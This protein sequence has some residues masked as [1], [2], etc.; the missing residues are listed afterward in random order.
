MRT[1]VVLG[2]RAVRPQHHDGAAVQ[3][4]GAL[5]VGRHVVAV[6]VVHQAEV[7]AALQ[8]AAVDLGLLGGDHL[9]LSLRVALPELPDGRGE[10][11]GGRAVDR[12][13]P[14]QPD[15]PVLL[16][17]RVLEPV[18]RVEQ[19]EDVREELA[20][21]VAHPRPVPAPVEQVH[22]QLPFQA[23]HGAAQRGL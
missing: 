17:G 4:R 20:A 15:A 21:G 3:Q 2:E 12:A 14:H 16:V 23:A 7:E 10:Q 11:R 19:G 13:K 22:A 8:D 5:E 9:D 1:A 18:E 6:E